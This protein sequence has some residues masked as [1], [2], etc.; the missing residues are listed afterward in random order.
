MRCLMWVPLPPLTPR[1]NTISA[2]QSALTDTTVEV[3][4][5][6]NGNPGADFQSWSVSGA[7]TCTQGADDGSGDKV[8]SCTGLAGGTSYTAKCTGIL[9]ADKGG[10]QLVAAKPFTT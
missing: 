9:L 7:G 5:Q 2:S 4:C 6:L 8:F 3:T 1:Y 10:G